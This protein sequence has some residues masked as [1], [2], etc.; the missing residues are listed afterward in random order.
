MLQ[1][2]EEDEKMNGKNEQKNENWEREQ[3]SKNF[4]SYLVSS[5]FRQT[6]KPQPN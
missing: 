6:T 5:Y 2:E 3:K 1:K 4:D